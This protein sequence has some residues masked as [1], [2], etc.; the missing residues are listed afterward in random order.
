MFEGVGFRILAMLVTVLTVVL[1]VVCVAASWGVVI[2]DQ[3][4]DP[5]MK[6]P[7]AL[8][9][10]TLSVLFQIAGL[11]VLLYFPH[12]LPE[13]PIFGPGTDRVVWSFLLLASFAL[14]VSTLWL[15]RKASDPATSL[16]RKSSIL[17]LTIWVLGFLSYVTGD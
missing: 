4:R 3:D 7:Y 17:L 5:S 1:G 13:R 8:Y 15:A 16:L 2:S 12:D 14:G 11:L 9:T 6:I 10:L